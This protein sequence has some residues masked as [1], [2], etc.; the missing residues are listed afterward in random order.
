MSN[1]EEQQRIIRTIHELGHL[2]RDKVLSQVSARYYWRSISAD[3]INFVSYIHQIKFHHPC[4][5]CRSSVVMCA[6]EWRGSL[7]S[8]PCLSIL[9]QCS[10]EPGSKLELIW[11]VHFLWHKLATSTLWLSPII[12][13]SGLKPKQYHQRK[14][15]VLLNFYTNSSCVMD[16]APL[17]SQIKDGN[18]VIESL[19]NIFPDRY[20]TSS[21]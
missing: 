21:N 17:S 15:P 8:Q 20:R 10:V 18:F 13:Q 5:L 9:F 4:T 14:P 16:S 19:T 11:L 6:N 7:I 2:G 3:V 12:S 1:K